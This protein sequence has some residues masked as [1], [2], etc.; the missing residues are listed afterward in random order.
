[1]RMNQE[2][3]IVASACMLVLLFLETVL[4]HNLELY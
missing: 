2:N 3:T 4:Y 1:M